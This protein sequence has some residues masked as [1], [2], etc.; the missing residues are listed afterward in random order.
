MKTAAEFIT[1]HR[2]GILAGILLLCAVCAYMALQ[3]PINADMTKYLPDDS[4]MKQGMDRMAE[5][6]GA[7]KLPQ[8][9]RVMAE[10]LQ[11]GEKE[12]FRGQ[13]EQLPDVD[14]VV[15]TDEKDQ[16]T[17]YTVSTSA[18]Y[19]S[20]A[21]LALEGS[22]KKLS[23][24]G[25]KVTVCTD[26][27][28]GMRIPPMLFVLAGV[29]LLTVLFVMCGS[30]TE[31][32]LFLATIG[33]AIVMNLGTNLVLGSVS[34]T[35]YSMAAVLQL[36]LS[37]DYSVILMNRYR[38]EKQK[39]AEN[40]A[41]AEETAG[42]QTTG[43]QIT[44]AQAA[45][46]EAAMTAAWMQAF[47]SIAS[48]GFTT[49]V[50]LLMLV[51]MRFKIGMDLGLV[52]AKGVFL[53]MVCVLLFL[54]GL[55]LYFDRLI[56]KTRKKTLHI[57]T[58]PLAEFGY[59]FR[60]V[61]LII[62]PVLLLGSGYLQTRSDISY[63]LGAEDPIAQVF[64]P[65]NPIVLLYPIAD[66]EQAA[67]LAGSLEKE[68]Q[69][70][71]V[72]AYSTTLGRQMSPQEL[73]DYVKDMT[74]QAG[75]YSAVLGDLDLS[76]MQ[77]QI[78]SLDGNALQAVYTLYGMMHGGKAPDTL[79]IQELFA[80]LMEN[81]DNPLLGAI[82]GE[83]TKEQLREMGQVLDAAR[84]QLQ[85]DHYAIMMINTVLPVEGEQTQAFI[86]KIQAFCEEQIQ[87]EYYLIG[88]SPMAYEMK[89]GFGREL[90]TISLLTAGAVFLVVA[91]TFRQLLLPLLLVLLVQC[92]VFMTIMTSHL[93][94]Y[95]IYYLAVIILQCILMGATVDYGILF[96]NYYRELRRT[97]PADRVLEP[98]FERSLHT[99]LTSSMFMIFVT[100][101]IGV[102][103]VDATIAQICRSIALG[104]ISALVLV[105][106]VLPGLLC[107]T[108]RHI[109]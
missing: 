6:F 81:L 50:G 1:A 16:Y 67:K 7:L 26:E 91:F 88:N 20:A 83:E 57:P 77:E 35:T 98:V 84:A 11:E 100:G 108:D 71:Q 48:S 63:A 85:G 107:A 5:E 24:E 82:A 103:P 61:I 47:P 4:S 3:V 8:T 66:E 87:E 73:A 56:E 27:T 15:L 89:G 37:M 74:S 52:L 55:I 41:A 92:G 43:K 34:Q 19:G 46:N 97:W 59:R 60:Y 68:E 76:G 96:A 44:G 86:E 10:N 29:I 72:L 9:I 31:P 38:Q 45:G 80:F 18:L 109:R 28:T 69:V 12:S 22:L 75:A 94:G 39:A 30:W 102:S 54:P 17:L 90:L 93:I 99:I 101:A 14:S 58:G 36:V 104:A 21:E 51:F 64:T 40:R 42:K 62:F 49:L 2:R 78:N 105:L 70:S 65:A 13:I 32:F 33:I 25:R 53:S 79:S 95:S 106:F 23:Q